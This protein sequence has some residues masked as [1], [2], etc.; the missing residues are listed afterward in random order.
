MSP[1]F[2]PTAF[3]GE[4][5]TGISYDSS[6]IAFFER[7]DI[8][9]T[10]LKDAVNDLVVDL[11]NEGLWTKMYCIYP[12]VTD[13]STSSGSLVQFQVNLVNTASYS[14]GGSSSF[15]NGES[16]TQD[17]S[18][19]KAGQSTTTYMRT[20]L[21]PS[22]V[23]GDS[24]NPYHVSLY[25]NA[26]GSEPTNRIDLGCNI[27]SNQTNMSLG[28]TYSGL[29]RTTF[30]ARGF[31]ALDAPSQ[32]TYKGHFIGTSKYS[33]SGEYWHR[34]TRDGT[35]ITGSNDSDSFGCGSIELFIGTVNNSGTPFPPANKRYQFFSF[36][37]NLTGT[38]CSTFSTIVNNFQTAVDNIYST[39][40]HA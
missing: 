31:V 13:K 3:L 33:A 6:S 38:E 17:K 27:G 9:D 15:V 7:A 28:T 22:T 16:Q 19:F 36:G 2:Q 12:F 29:S 18:G 4:S 30:E 14:G 10:Q 20:G 8:T 24:K 5:I 39:D 37:D 23:I 35:L 40:R 11:K 25:T 1:I 21:I 34:I 26:T 32:S